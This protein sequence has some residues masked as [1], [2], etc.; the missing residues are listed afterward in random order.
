MAHTLG[1]WLTTAPYRH[2]T[3]LHPGPEDGSH[4]PGHRAAQHVASGH[5]AD[6]ALLPGALAHQFLDVGLHSRDD[7][8]GRDSLQQK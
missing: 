3:D 7:R 1:G 5:L 4:V 8:W 6:R 2:A